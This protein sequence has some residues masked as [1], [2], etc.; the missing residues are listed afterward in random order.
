MPAGDILT[1]YS[2]VPAEKNIDN[3]KLNSIVG[4][5]SI[6]PAF[7]SAQTESTSSTT[8]DY[9][10][11]LKAGGTLAKIMSDNVA[12]SLASSS[13]FQS[14]IWSTRLRSYNAVG[15]PGFE[16]D[17]ANVGNTLTNVAT[18]TRIADRWFLGKAG[19][20]TGTI[21]TQ[22][23][24]ISAGIKLPGTNFVITGNQQLL[25][26]G[27]TQAALAAGDQV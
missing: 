9:Y 16:V 27:T 21:N 23:S 2:F 3:T 20:V 14:Q 22:C 10:L 18:N 4:Q 17:Q 26:I 8:G 15:N 5:A 13:G 19:S 11:L 24:R 7:I 1:G 6:Q 25:Q 12:S